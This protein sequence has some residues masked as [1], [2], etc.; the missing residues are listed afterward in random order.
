MALIFI[1]RAKKLTLHCLIMRPD[2]CKPKRD[3]GVVMSVQESK[4]A[5]KVVPFAPD[6]REPNQ[7]TSVDESGRS[8]VALLERAAG[9]A[10]DDCTRAM[11]LAHRLTFQLREAEERVRALEDDAA[12]FRDRA[13]RAEDWLQHIHK[14]IE[15]TFFQQK[16]PTRTRKPN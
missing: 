1:T 12:H 13:V 2:R 5:A 14:Q 4:T 8:I 15:Q 10:K 9:M 6:T 11:D 7:T 16:D 3:G